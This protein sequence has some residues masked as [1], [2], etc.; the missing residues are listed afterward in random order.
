MRLHVVMVAAA[1]ASFVGGASGCRSDPAP[2]SPSATA[3][4]GATSAAAS[5]AVPAPTP[6]LVF[7]PAAGGDAATVVRAELETATREG[8]RLVVYVGASWCEPCRRF[9]DSAVAGA[10]DAKLPPIRFVEFDA[11]EDE[12]RLKAAGYGSS[13]VPLFAIPAADGRASPKRIEGSIKGAG[14]PAEI[15][16]RLLRL[17]EETA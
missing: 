12:A 1:V 13:W 7:V 9:H 3:T 4:S 10:L 5:A 14:A 16:P 17:L 2:G 11:D 6:R 15:T 8:R